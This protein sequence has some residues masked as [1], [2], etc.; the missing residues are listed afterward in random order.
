MDISDFLASMQTD[1]Q[2]KMLAKNTDVHMGIPDG[3]D[4]QADQS[5]LDDMQ[6]DQSIPSGGFDV[7][8][9][10]APDGEGDMSYAEGGP[11]P[12]V[13]HVH[14]RAAQQYTAQPTQ[15]FAEGG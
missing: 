8:G 12:G 11:I 15:S 3:S 13:Q 2:S 1:P 6:T 5:A 10:D 14:K 9:F 4:P 7:G